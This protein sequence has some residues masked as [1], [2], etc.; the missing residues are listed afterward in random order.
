MT[1]DLTKAA[2]PNAATEVAKQI[3]QPTGDDVDLDGWGI[4]FEEWA[5]QVEAEG[6]AK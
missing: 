6:K 2:G 3:G 5:A 4:P 1:D